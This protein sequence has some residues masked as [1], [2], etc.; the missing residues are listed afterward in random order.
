MHNPEETPNPIDMNNVASTPKS[1]SKPKP[2][3]NLPMDI[4]P[5][6]IIDDTDDD[7]ELQEAI[8]ASLLLQNQRGK[9]R[10]IIDLD[11]YE[12]YDDDDEV[13]FLY[14]SPSCKKTRI[15]IG[16][17]SNSPSS[18]RCSSTSTT[19]TFDCE[20]CIETKP[21]SESFPILGCTHS[22]CSD[23]IVKYVSSKLDQNITHIPCPVSDCKKGVLYPDHCY[24]IL[25][26]E[27]FDRW[28][29]VLCESAFLASQK[30]YCPFKDCSALMIDDGGGGGEA[31]GEAEC[32]NC[33]RKFCAR[34]KVPWHPGIQ[35][36][37]FQKLNKDEREKEDIMLMNL[38]KKRKWARCPNCKIY[39]AKN[40]GC[41]HMTCRCGCFFSYARGNVYSYPSPHLRRNGNL[42]Q[43]N[44]YLNQSEL[45][46]TFTEL[47]ATVSVIISGKQVN[48][49]KT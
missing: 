5:I 34:C 19:I 24:P 21:K 47:L 22:Y 9:K 18:S 2:S 4:N 1:E 8:M 48:R 43:T 7:R 36:S 41:D 20:I 14:S 6:E 3:H 35:C 29:S 12:S 31:I 11:A 25:P 44:G 23:C 42:A 30:F 39:I 40:K 37:E 13:Q 17:S 32:P 33:N 49:S 27:L 15:E 28:G 10:I 45:M 38:A 16:E 26:P 46:G